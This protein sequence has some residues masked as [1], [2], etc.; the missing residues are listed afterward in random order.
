MEIIK[1]KE[2]KFVGFQRRSAKRSERGSSPYGTD[3]EDDDEKTNRI[4]GKKFSKSKGVP[5]SLSPEKSNSSNSPV[6][7]QSVPSSPVVNGNGSQRCTSES[8]PD[9]TPPP[10]DLPPGCWMLDGDITS[11]SDVDVR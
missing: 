5:E 11:L 7:G 1:A 2:F 9:V 6:N 8:L 4:A 3:H 10:V